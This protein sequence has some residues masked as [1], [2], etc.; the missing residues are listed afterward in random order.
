MKT[1]ASER[2]HIPWPDCMDGCETLDL[3]GKRECRT[4]SK[5]C[6]EKFAGNDDDLLALRER[7]ATLEGRIRVMAVYMGRSNR[8]PPSIPIKDEC[9]FD[10][11]ACW[12]ERGLR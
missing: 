6:A 11:A 2:E 9:N 12:S 8:C 5:A 4:I 1:T 10:C 3:F 7:V